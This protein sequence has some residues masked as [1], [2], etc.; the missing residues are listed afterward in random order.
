MKL[1]SISAS[2]SI[3][4]IASDP[5]EGYGPI[6]ILFFL[7]SYHTCQNTVKENKEYIID[8]TA[9]AA[10]A[11][12]DES[13]F[14]ELVRCLYKKLF[15]FAVSLIKSEAEA[16]DILQEAFL[17]IWLHRSALTDI[18]NPSGW[19]FTIVANTASN[20]LR[21][22]I[23][24]E[25]TIKKF[26]SRAAVNEE[27]EG[28]IDARFTQSLIDEA[29]SL[30]PAKRKLVFLLSKKEGLSRRE[31]AARLNISE[32]TVRNQLSEAMHSVHKYLSRK[33]DYIF[34]L[35]FILQSLIEDFFSRQ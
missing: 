5:A 4:S 31:I 3:A 26:N 33:G 9:L 32:N 20:H 16:D 28:E 13:V 1:Q 17:K 15:P 14:A 22:R 25:L 11:R 10:I 2:R 27:I 34:P 24:N 19:I 29:V 18:E 23:R 12:G 21:S 30:L 35:L 6:K 8:K 7:P